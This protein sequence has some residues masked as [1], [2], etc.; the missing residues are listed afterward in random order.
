MVG[1]YRDWVCLHQPTAPFSVIHVGA[2]AP[3]IPQALI[4]QVSQSRLAE[5]PS[6]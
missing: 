2:A 6:S 5:G 1:E 4:N 3:S